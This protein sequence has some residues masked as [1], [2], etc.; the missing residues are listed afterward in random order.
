[1]KNI[2]N[3]KTRK[4]VCNIA[5]GLVVS[6]SCLFAET[7]DIL[8]LKEDLRNENALVRLEAV[9]KAATHLDEELVKVLVEHLR[10]E[11]DNHIKCVIIETIS[12]V[13]S[14][15]VFYALKEQIDSSNNSYV[16][17]VALMGISSFQDEATFEILK[18][19]AIKDKDIQLR[20]V[21]VFSLRNFKSTSSV[22]LLDS[23]IANEKEP[24]EL[25]ILAIKSLSAIGNNRSIEI[26]SK[27]SRHKDKEISSF[28]G[29]QLS[30]VRKKNTIR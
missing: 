18:D 4:R 8:K 25:R 11:V 15:E 5:F 19:V 27:Y 30:E 9:N 29:S 6:V 10:K 28:A 13:K 20:K 24:K 2:I 3:E 1:M 7:T 26:L 14:T 12:I 17:Q 23:L 16:K 21:A 22:E